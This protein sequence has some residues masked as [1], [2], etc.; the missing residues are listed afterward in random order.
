M[1]TALTSQTAQPGLK[2]SGLASGREEDL[3]RQ[4]TGQASTRAQESAGAAGQQAVRGGAVAPLRSDAILALQ[5]VDKAEDK[6][7]QQAGTATGG[8]QDGANASQSA[9]GKKE[10]TGP[11]GLTEGEEK[12]VRELKK[13]DREVRAHEQAHARAGGPYASAPTYTFQQG[14]DGGRYAI[15]GEV[16]IDTSAEQTPEATARKMQIVIRAALAP[17]DPSSQDLKVA[18]QARATLQAAQAE[19]RKENAEELQGGDDTDEAAGIEGAEGA[20]E[21][22]AA[23]DN[24]TG[25]DTGSDSGTPNGPGTDQPAGDRSGQGSAGDEQN[26]FA[27]Q[28][29]E[30]RQA[31]EAAATRLVEA[32]ARAANGLFGQGV[33][34]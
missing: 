22:N 31:Y 12:Q 10:G 26:G 34:A 16:Q 24:D 3:D 21:S 9:S 5:G 11:D 6:K 30:A 27:R 8:R 7:A 20:S 17:A 13:R 19:A 25:A 4:L 28:S 1:L 15:G 29:E 18:A 23:G 32:T 2:G 14:P 33:V